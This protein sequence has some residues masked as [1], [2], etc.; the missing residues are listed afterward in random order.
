MRGKT[1]AAVN[2]GT[3]RIYFILKLC[4]HPR[5]GIR[6]HPERIR[7]HK[8]GG[9]IIFPRAPPHRRFIEATWM[10]EPQEHREEQEDEEAPNNDKG[11]NL[12][13]TRIAE[14]R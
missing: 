12:I 13:R 1:R 7:L 6:H 9:G 8:V 5:P 4:G 3:T 14:V 11:R 2:G 10:F